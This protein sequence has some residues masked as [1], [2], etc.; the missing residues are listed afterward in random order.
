MGSFFTPFLV[1]AD[2]LNGEQI[3][4]Q[5]IQPDAPKSEA[6]QP[7][8]PK[9]EADQS[10]NL[11]L[12]PNGERVPLPPPYMLISKNELLPLSFYDYVH[13]SGMLI[14][15]FGFLVGSVTS[16][17]FIIKIKNESPS[18]MNNQYESYDGVVLLITIPFTIISGLLWY[19]S[20]SAA[21]RM[22]SKRKLAHKT[23]IFRENYNEIKRQKPPKKVKPIISHGLF[24]VLFESAF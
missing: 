18:A 20:Y 5:R 17:A 22:E 16:T 21:E 10:D 13:V 3:E 11:Y 8:A 24:G 9:S 4:L 7:D 6:I 12:S 15:G 19:G 2:E 1:Y 23:G 14:G